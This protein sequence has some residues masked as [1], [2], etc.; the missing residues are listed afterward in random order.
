MNHCIVYLKPIWLYINDTYIKNSE[1]KP[2]TKKL[3][4]FKNERGCCYWSDGNK[5]VYNTV[6][7]LEPSWNGQI[8]ERCKQPVLTAE[9]NEY[10]NRSLTEKRLN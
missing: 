4:N 8:P 9:E 10:L 2:R 3:T 5:K 7:K 6:N 1:K